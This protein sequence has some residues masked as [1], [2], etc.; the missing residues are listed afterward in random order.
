MKKIIEVKNLSKIFNIQTKRQWFK[1]R[2]KDFFVPQYKQF[3]AVDNISFS[4]WEWEKIAFLWPNWAGKSTTIKMLTGILHYTSGE[5]SVCWLDPIKNRKQ[6]VYN[7]WAIFGQ[8]SRLW[9]H[10]TAMD[11][12]KIVAKMF[13][14]PD[15]VFQKRINFL[16]SKFGIEDIIT[17]PVR[18]LS[19]WQRMKC[20]VI[21]SLIHSPKV[22]FLDEP[23]I[24]LDI[25]AKQNLR[26]IIN[27]INETENTT[28]FLTS[29][30]LWDVEKIC[31]RVIIINYWKV[32]YDGS[33]KE[34]RKNHIKTKTLK[35]NFLNGK[36][37]K[38]LDFMQIINRESN[39]VEIQ[40]PNDKDSL[41]QTFELINTG[42]EIED[43]VIENPSIED[44]I[45]QFY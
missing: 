44:V 40:I 21:V 30:D 11:T 41:N 36:E 26:D 27:Q 18:K 3:Q 22:L 35:I 42:Y 25:I 45:K 29:H 4:V 1:N 2:I 32:L 23:T 33:I 13:D 16:I 12:F 19:L 17:R 7:I 10:L 15:D 20:E 14:V 37:F 31:D 6:L 24:G 5:V 28:I 8:T 9:Y 38:P 34:L 39:Y 43:I